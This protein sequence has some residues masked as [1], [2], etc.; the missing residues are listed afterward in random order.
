MKHP[1]M[2]IACA[3]VALVSFALPT[4]AVASTPSVDLT[5]Y[6]GDW[7]EI[8]SIPQPFQA[9]CSCTQANYT[10]SEDGSVRVINAC[11]RGG[12]WTTI[13]GRAIS[14][15]PGVNTQLSV[16]FPQSPAGSYMI[17][18]VDPEY[19]FAVV[20]SHDS[21]A[22]WILARGRVLAPSLLK[23]AIFIAASA[24]D[25]TGFSFTDQRQCPK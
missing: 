22:L 12:Q 2:A 1:M 3:A 16:Q 25:L 14:L 7:Y 8:G 20:T 23:E 18:A 11:L 15:N 24:V 17:L 19:R 10:L 4:L 5:R 6:Q 9:G 13:T 21:H